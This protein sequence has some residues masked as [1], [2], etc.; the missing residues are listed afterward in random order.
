MNH[1][2]EV[3]HATLRP[4]IC[5]MRHGSTY[6]NIRAMGGEKI[7]QTNQDPMSERGEREVKIA[8]GNL[9]RLITEAA[10]TIDRPWLVHYSPLPRARHTKDIALATLQ[11]AGVLEDNVREEPRPELKERLVNPVITG[12]SYVK[13][14]QDET[15]QTWYQI[16]NRLIPYVQ[17]LR[18]HVSERH[19]FVVGHGGTNG[20]L[21]LMLEK[22]LEGASKTLERDSYHGPVAGDPQSSDWYTHKTPNAAIDLYQRG[23][24]QWQPLLQVRAW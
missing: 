5:L 18:E 7:H 9:A 21:R 2:P 17:E 6:A 11:A 4:D 1:A 23:H 22:G 24:E 13:E 14:Y 3:T 19:V 16:Y 10:V 20:M 8:A 12:K 15:H